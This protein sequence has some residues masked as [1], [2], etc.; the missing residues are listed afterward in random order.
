MERFANFFRHK[1]FPDDLFWRFLE[2]TEQCH[3]IFGLRT[4]RSK[5]P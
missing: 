5:F 1:K 3:F 2:K 4:Q